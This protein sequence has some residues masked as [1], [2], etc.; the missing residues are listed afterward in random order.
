MIPAI[1][2][3]FMDIKL[4]MTIDKYLGWFCFHYYNRHLHMYI[5]VH[6][7]KFLLGINSQRGIAELEDMQL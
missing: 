1:K 6:V 3:Q 5:F 2:F 7:S 4:F